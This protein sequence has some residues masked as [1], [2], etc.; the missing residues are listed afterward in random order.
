MSSVL[1]V[2]KNVFS[3]ELFP[4]IFFLE[5]M[6]FSGSDHIETQLL[7]RHVASLFLFLLSLVWRLSHVSR[8]LRVHASRCVQSNADM[9]AARIRQGELDREEEAAWYIQQVGLSSRNVNGT[10]VCRLLL[11]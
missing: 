3:E 6:F 1:R 4:D 9:R 8:R 5:L 10:G 2:A 11:L 7:R